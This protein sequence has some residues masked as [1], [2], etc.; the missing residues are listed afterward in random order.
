MGGNKLRER[1]KTQ[2]PCYGLWVTMESPTL[3][4][5]AGALGMD[6][7]CVDMEHGHLDYAEV[8]EHIRAARGSQTTV[9]VRVPSISQDKVK[10]VLD[11]GAHGVILPLVR[12]CQDVETGM[13]FGRYP[14][15]GVRGIGGE[16]AVQWGLGYNEYLEAANQETLII[17]L[18]ETKEAAENI[19]EIL[20]VPGVEAIFFGPADL[21]ASYGYLGQWEGPGIASQILEMHAKARKK[22]IVAGVMSTSLEDGVQ[23]RDQGFGM[24]GLGSDAGLLIRSINEAMERFVGQT[25]KHL[26]F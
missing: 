18:I 17:P 9:L 12:S 26:W 13:R 3:T 16:R 22:G 7:V 4:E 19:D 11:M 21:S 15:K 24:V 5:I 1:F 25:T 20:D 8:M 23:R 6:W 2:E 14:P 10:R